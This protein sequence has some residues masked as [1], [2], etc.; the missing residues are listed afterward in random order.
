MKY[1]RV[2]ILTAILSVLLGVRGAS[3]AS[4]GGAAANV[5]AEGAFAAENAPT[6]QTARSDKPI[7]TIS[8][9]PRRTRLALFKAQQHRDKGDFESSAAVLREFLVE[10][11]DGDHF[12]LRFYLA[13]NLIQLERQEEALEHYQAAVRLEERYGQGWLNLGETAYN[14]ERYG[15]AAEA[16]MKG[17]EYSENKQPRLIYFAAVSH[18]MDQKPGRAA[19]LLEELISGSYGEP[20]IDWYKALISAT[21]DMEAVDRGR[22]AVS[23]MLNDFPDDPAAWLLAFQ[24]AAGANEYRQAAVALTVVGYLRPLTRSEEMML[25]DLYNALEIPARASLHYGRAVTD[26]GTPKEYERLASAHLASYNYE[27]AR[28]TLEAAIAKKPTLRLWALLG[29]LHYMQKNYERAYRAF[30]KCAALDAEYGRAYLMMGYCALEMGKV[31]EA[32]PHLHL[33]AKYPQQEETARALLAR[34]AESGK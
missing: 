27:A 30:Q 14:L 16:I 23:G 15:L 13:N 25:G 5:A 28:E 17:Y 29:D 33:A 8:D 21:L 19:P 10:H 9:V 32:V 26:E 22:R 11:P 4:A 18:M 31:G 12:L 24:F 34:V 3:I 1:S 6:G 2:I 20:E 7:D